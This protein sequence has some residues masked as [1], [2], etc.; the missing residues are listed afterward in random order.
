MLQN[1]I[2]V[3]TR[4]HHRSNRSCVCVF[5]CVRVCVRVCLYIYVCVCVCVRAYL[6]WQRYSAEQ[7][8]LWGLTHTIGRIATD[9]TI[10]GI[11]TEI[12]GIGTEREN[13]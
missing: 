7:A 11:G 12:T 3:R 4:A 9:S 5:V 8:L 13:E 1:K 2:S 6:G 10:A